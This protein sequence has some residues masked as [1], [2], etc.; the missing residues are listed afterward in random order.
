MKVTK[1]LLGAALVSAAAMLVSCSDLSSAEESESSSSRAAAT[2]YYV[3]TADQLYTAANK[4]NGGDTIVLNSNITLTKQLQLLRSG[5]SGSVITL[6]GNGKTLDC[7]KF[8]GWGVKVNGSYWTIKNLTVKNASDCGLVFQ[9]GGN[10]RAEYCKFLNNGDSGLQVYNSAHDVTVTKCESYYNYD[11]ATGGENADGFAA[12]LSGGKN[13]KFNYCIA[14]YN[15]DDGWDL[16]S[17]P[18]QVTMNHCEASYNGYINS[19]YQTTSDGDGNG[20]KLGSKYANVSHRVL[21]CT[22]KGNLKYGID[23]NGNTAKQTITGC[24][25]TNNKEGQISSRTKY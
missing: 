10:N 21:Y 13:I 17:Q 24:T 2:T 18:Y 3:S 16:Y 23:A 4:V 6:N 15:S 20:F 5:S 12:K 9:I 8:T 19:S 7:S 11:K 1:F 14:K 25:V 22:A